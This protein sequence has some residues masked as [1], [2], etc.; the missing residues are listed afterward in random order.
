MN[1]IVGIL[2]GFIAGLFFSR[3]RSDP[4]GDAAKCAAQILQRIFDWVAKLF[5]GRATARF[6]EGKNNPEN[7]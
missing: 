2:I 3:D 4:V 6:P 7:R 5:K 1:L